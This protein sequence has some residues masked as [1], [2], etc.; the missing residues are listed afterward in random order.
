M[1]YCLSTSLTGKPCLPSRMAPI[2][3]SEGFQPLPPHKGLKEEK[4][5]EKSKDFHLP[6]PAPSKGLKEGEGLAQQCLPAC[7]GGNQGCV[8]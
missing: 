1:V 3:R 5:M 6:L 7:V 4:P 2:A 8:F